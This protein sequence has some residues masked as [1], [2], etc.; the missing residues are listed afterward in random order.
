MSLI[1]TAVAPHPPLLIPSIGKEN[2][3][4]LEKTKEALEKLEEELYLTHPDVIL[5][6]TPHARHFPDAFSVNMSPLFE[7]D[8]KDFGDLTTKLPLRGEMLLQYDIRSAAYANKECPTV[9]INEPNLDYSAV[10]PLIYLTRHMPNVK[11]LPVGFSELSPKAHWEFG[12]VIREQI[13]RTNKRIA[14]I[15]SA[16]LSHAL[17]SEAPA[18]YNE[19]GPKFDAKIQELFSA[20]NL[21]GLLTLDQELVKNA[22]ECGFRSLLIMAGIL[23]DTN[24]R[25]ESFAY[26]SPFGVGYLTANFAL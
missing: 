16:D 24:Y 7:C 9:V 15:A 8:L 17:S 13:I 23:K 6:I 12:W 19:A 14:V 1:F 3:S 5:I 18:G 22:S 11:I 2:I 21:S 26:E 10:V 25:Y 4:K 20:H